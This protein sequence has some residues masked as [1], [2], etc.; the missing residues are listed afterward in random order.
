MVVGELRGWGLRVGLTGLLLGAP[1]VAPAQQAALELLAV[2]EFWKTDDGS[3]LLAL[4]QG[5]P[6]LEGRLAAWGVLRPHRA[7]SL[8]ALA[9]A[10]AGEAGE[11]DTHVEVEELLARIELHPALAIE[12][13]RLLLPVG[14]FSLRRF[15][16]SNPLIGL[17]DTYPTEYPWGAQLSGVAG[18]FDYR[19]A[20]VNLPALNERY[21]PAPGKRL[22]PAAAIGVRTGPDLRVGVSATYGPY[23]GANVD[24]ALA[25]GVNRED[26]KETIL[27]AEARYSR[28]HLEAWG[29]LLWTSY[30][31]PT[32]ADNVDGLGFYLELK[33]TL[34]PRLYVAGR[35]E[36]N[37]YAFVLPVSSAFWVGT[38]RTVLDGEIG[39]GYR[40]GRD[41]LLKAS[42]RRDRWPEAAQPGG[43]S[44][45]DGY[46][47]A[48]QASYFVDVGEVLA[49][50]Y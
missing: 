34:T 45:P 23:L 5:D 20:L 22:R 35:F 30:E 39:M 4:N 46:A 24:G 27:G 38:A 9:E 31:V 15:A 26:F 19:A 50:R 47:V 32:V 1:S 41:F 8:R 10:T 40:L 44:F 2:G 28:G 7:V 49:R 25:A 37:R 3:R 33:A 11:Y 18:P 14:A 48:V 36:R 42:Y 12:G 16:N 17:P 21:F 43:P 29:E 6:T 13:G